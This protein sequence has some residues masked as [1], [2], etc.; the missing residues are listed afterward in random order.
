MLYFSPLYPAVLTFA[1]KKYG[2]LSA[3]ALLLRDKKLSVLEG[4]G[5]HEFTVAKTK[6]PGISSRPSLI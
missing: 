5:T 4:Q 2:D 1:T 6:R 3:R